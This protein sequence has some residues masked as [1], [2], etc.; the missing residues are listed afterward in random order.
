MTQNEE[1]ICL[2]PYT[3]RGVENTR[4]D[5]L[6]AC[7]DWLQVT[8]KAVGNPNKIIDLLGMDQVDFLPFENGKYGYSFHLRHGH[9]AIYFNID[10]LEDDYQPSC[11]LEMSGQGCREFEQVGKYDWSTFL[12]LVLMLDVNITRLDLAIDDKKG[13]FTFAKL[14]KKLKQRFDEDNNPYTEVRSRFHTAKIFESFRLA[15]GE[16]L[17][18]TI[19]FGSP[20]SEIQVRIYDKLKQILH[21][22]VSTK[23]K[24]AREELE[25]QMKHIKTWIR[26]EMQLRDE[27][28][29]MAASILANHQSDEKIGEQIKGHLKNYINFVD[30][31]PNDKNKSRWKVSD[32]WTRFLDDVEKLPLTQKSPDVSIEKAK[33]WIEKSVVA[34]FNTV[35]EAYDYNA[36]LVVNFL[37]A[38]M[39]KQK[40]KH[41]N[42][43][44][45][46]RPNF[47]EDDYNELMFKRDEFINKLIDIKKESTKADS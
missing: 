25:E 4:E 39:Q 43:L 28:A 2:P 36:E 40:K 5:S 35:L 44:K 30:F 6:T 10:T 26:T 17:G 31:N 47:D 33:D 23:D 15:D 37:V 29:I 3:N 46:F 45:T 27:R 20:S 38:G 1:K 16:N 8:F 9:I 7:V 22:N 41:L 32:F 34:N 14:K 24:K 19:Y 13:Y 18:T 11:H 21:K 42:M 12:G